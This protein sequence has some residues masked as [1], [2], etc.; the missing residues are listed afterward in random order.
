MNIVA[1]KMCQVIVPFFGSGD[2]DKNDSPALGPLD[3]VEMIAHII[4]T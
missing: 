3:A 1:I 2:R 4:G